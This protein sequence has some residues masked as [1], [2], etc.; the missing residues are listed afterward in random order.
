MS[1]AY[2]IN[3]NKKMN[4]FGI[5]LENIFEN[6]DLDNRD[7]QKW[8]AVPLKGALVQQNGLN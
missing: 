5:F 6:C 4:I 3:E 8:I 7:R 2:S 1:W